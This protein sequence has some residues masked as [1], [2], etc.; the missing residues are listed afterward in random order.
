MWLTIPRE[1]ER[2]FVTCSPPFN[3]VSQARPCL[4]KCEGPACETTFS[5][6][7]GRAESDR[8]GLHSPHAPHTS[9]VQV[10]SELGGPAEEGNGLRVSS[11]WCT[12]FI[13]DGPVGLVN[14]YKIVTVRILYHVI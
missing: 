4:H 7:L 3:V 1:R 10:I 9:V 2:E 6:D 8:L 11:L 13:H 14:L 12:V 5:V